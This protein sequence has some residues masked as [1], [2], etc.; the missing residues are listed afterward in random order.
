LS[1]RASK[2]GNR[3]PVR[4]ARQRRGA[5]PPPEAATLHDAALDYLA[6][7]AATEAGLL[8]VLER[9]VDR[10][11]RLAV[12]EAGTEDD[13][14][15][16]AS[17][18]RRIVR[19]VVRRL[20]AAGVVNDRTFAESRSRT[21][22]RAGRSRLAVAAHLAA[23]GV[24]AEVSRSVLAANETNEIAAA[25]ALARRRRIGPFRM[26]GPPDQAALQHEL[27]ILAR[28][29]FPQSVAREALAMAS[30]EAEALVIQLRR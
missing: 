27:A 22:I 6:R 2:A 5:G 24:D 1:T 10:W 18:A 9:L 25:L 23:K 4:S 15:G 12:A 17:E 20:M 7:Y 28:A 26:G 16:Q 14:A 21:L 29:G 19:E 11:A 13:V 30:D 3:S 8:R